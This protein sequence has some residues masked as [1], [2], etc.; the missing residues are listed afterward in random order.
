MGCPTA[1]IIGNNLVFSICTHDPDTGHLTDT[2]APPIYRLYEDETVVPILTGTMAQLDGLNTTGFYTEL[3]AC[4]TANG[5]EAGRSYTVYIEATV[6][7]DTGGITYAFIV[8][9][10]TL[11]PGAIVF[12]YTLTSTVDGTPIDEVDVWVTSD[13]AGTNVL[14]SGQTNM[15]G[16]VVFM[17][18]AGTHYFWRQKDGWDFDPQPDVEVV[19]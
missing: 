7:S 15:A 1:V 6:D 4:T 13:I 18:D 14:A 5:F 10:T 2:D 9:P 12:T 19:S 3:I 16:Q 8:K 11:G 17:L